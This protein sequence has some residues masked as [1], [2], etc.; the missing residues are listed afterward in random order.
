MAKPRRNRGGGNGHLASARRAAKKP[1]QRIGPLTLPLREAAAE[2][3]MH[4]RTLMHHLRRTDAHCLVKVGNRFRIDRKGF[5]RWCR[6][7]GFES[8][9][10]P[11]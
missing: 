2:L 11:H 9:G 1:A 10:P 8:A 6:Q 3:D 5:F 4:P 7:L